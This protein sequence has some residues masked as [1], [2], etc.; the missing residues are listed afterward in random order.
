MPVNCIILDDEPLALQLLQHY[1]AQLPELRLLKAFDNPYEARAYLEVQPVDL[2]LL[3]IDMP[4]L[5]GISFIKSLT[6]IPQF[7][8]TTAHQK[9]AFDGFELEATDFLLKPFD[10][11]RFNKAITKV[12][13]RQPQTDTSIS[14]ITVYS[15]YRLQK[16]DINTIV[17]LEAMQDYVKIHL[18][19]KSFI[20][21][22]STLKGILSKL[23]PLHFIQVHRSY[24]ISLSQVIS[25]S[26][27]K[28][29]LSTAEVPVS[30]RHI[31]LLKSFLQ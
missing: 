14:S 10:I 19:T 17:Y 25:V 4:D 2:V 26:Q 15:E 6:H 1:I 9:Y 12:I 11:D 7:I 28:V 22:L 21:T 31:T 29:Q 23:P 8:F 3:D 24:V 30:K 18:T 20:L 13:K 27:G 16:I 5:D